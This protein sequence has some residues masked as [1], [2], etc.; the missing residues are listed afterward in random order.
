MSYGFSE[1]LSKARLASH[2]AHQG[3]ATGASARRREAKRKAVKILKT[4]DIMKYQ[5]S[6]P[7]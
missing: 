7:Q 3:G 1:F 6:L 2:K 4:N 5:I